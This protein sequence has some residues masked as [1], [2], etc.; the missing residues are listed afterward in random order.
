MT[1]VFLRRVSYWHALLLYVLGLSLI[2]MNIAIAIEAISWYVLVRS[3]ARPY[4]MLGFGRSWTGEENVALNEITVFR[5]IATYA[6]LASAVACSVAAYRMGSFNNISQD[7]GVLGEAE[8]LLEATYFSMVTLATV[9]YGDIVPTAD[10]GRV[11]VI[12]II[13]QSFLLVGFLL[14]LLLN[15]TS[16]RPQD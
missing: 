8:R 9:G 2:A 16:S 7:A 5:R 12:F 13:F 1:D 6:V 3:Y 14:S 15:V 10:S 4:F 11:I